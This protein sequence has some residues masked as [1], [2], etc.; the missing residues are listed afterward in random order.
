MSV[1]LGTDVIS[2]GGQGGGCGVEWWPPKRKV[3]TLAPG[4]CAWELNWR[5]GLCR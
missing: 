3:H 1:A 2:E 5:E 4:T